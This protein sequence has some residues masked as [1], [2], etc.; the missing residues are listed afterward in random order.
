MKDQN[1]SAFNTKA[2]NARRLPGPDS[3]VLL[4]TETDDTG[5]LESDAAKSN[6][7]SFLSLKSIKQRQK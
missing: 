3:K 5:L 6:C 2:A 4:Y 1:L 7:H